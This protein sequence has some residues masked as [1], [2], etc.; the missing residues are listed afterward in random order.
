M[1]LDKYDTF[2]TNTAACHSR[3]HQAQ[4]TK[5]IHKVTKDQSTWPRDKD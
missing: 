5:V 4:L 3:K 1:L 2:W